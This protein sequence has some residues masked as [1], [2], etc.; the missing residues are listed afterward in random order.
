MEPLLNA[1]GNPLEIPTADP[2]PPDLFRDRD[3]GTV[4]ILHQQL[5]HIVIEQ[6]RLFHQAEIDDLREQRDELAFA[7]AELAAT[8]AERDLRIRRLLAINEEQRRSYSHR[9]KCLKGTIRKRVREL[10][11]RRCE[12]AYFV[13]FS[14][15]VLREL[16]DFREAG[17]AVV[18]WLG[19]DVDCVLDFGCQISDGDWVWCYGGG[20]PSLRVSWRNPPCQELC[21]IAPFEEVR[22]ELR[23][24]LELLAGTEVEDANG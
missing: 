12:L 21:W 23:R 9:V 6:D 16:A 24:V 5:E 14:A 15:M 22:A 18:D 11:E 20:R 10:R 17:A 7:H 2:G 19:E 1:I 13:E 4:R 8:L 3:R